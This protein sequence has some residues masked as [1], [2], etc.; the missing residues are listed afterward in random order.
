MY[1]IVTSSASLALSIG[2][3]WGSVC[4]LQKYFPSSFLPTDRFYLQGF[5]AGLW[6][7]LVPNSRALDLG[8]Y[9]VRT[10]LP[11][12][13]GV[14]MKNSSGKGKGGRGILKRFRVKNGEVIYF[15]LSMGVLMTLWEVSSSFST[16]KLIIL[17]STTLTFLLFF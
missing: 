6:I 17:L 13:W 3:A 2:T 9:S 15:G 5:L 16:R 10:A 8:W 7:I 1:S 12:F 4:A 11:T 14:A